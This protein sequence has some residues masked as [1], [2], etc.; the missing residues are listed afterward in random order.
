MQ[1]TLCTVFS[2]LCSQQAN[3]PSDTKA[4]QESEVEE[5]QDQMEDKTMNVMLDDNKQCT[6][7]YNVQCSVNADLTSSE[8]TSKTFSA[9]D[10]PL[11]Q[12]EV[13]SRS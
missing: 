6:E 3:S 2:L 9:N 11:C 10:I 4:A 1:I 12:N 5:N 8:Q 7:K 13:Q